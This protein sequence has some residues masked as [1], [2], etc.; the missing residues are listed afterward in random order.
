VPQRPLESLPRLQAYRDPAL[1]RTE[2]QRRGYDILQILQA[3][4]DIGDP[5]EN[6]PETLHL[7]AHEMWD[8]QQHHRS[9]ISHLYVLLPILYLTRQQEPYRD[10]LGRVGRT[11]FIEL[12]SLRS[13]RDVALPDSI[14]AQYFGHLWTSPVPGRK[15]NASSQ[16]ADWADTL[17]IWIHPSGTLARNLGHRDEQDNEEEPGT[18]LEHQALMDEDSQR[19]GLTLLSLLNTEPKTNPLKEDAWIGFML[20][21]SFSGDLL[22]SLAHAI[23]NP[24]VDDL[25]T[26]SLQG[27][28]SL[29]K[30]FLDVK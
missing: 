18:D 5:T 17:S 10:K 2:A 29:Y 20:A 14:R 28:E 22:T 24:L 16:T 12:L 3:L 15:T 23:K 19:L 4:L 1:A 9:L 11:L 25:N 8:L 27:V 7:S 13:S 6:A 21:L 30:E 26:L